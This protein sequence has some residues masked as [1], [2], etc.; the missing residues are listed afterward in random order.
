MDYF[1]AEERTYG[2]QDSSLSFGGQVD[3]RRAADGSSEEIDVV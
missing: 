1:D 2:H 3:G